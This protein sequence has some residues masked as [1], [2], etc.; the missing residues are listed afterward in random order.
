[1]FTAPLTGSSVAKAFHPFGDGWTFGTLVASPEGQTRR[2]GTYTILESDYPDLFRTYQAARNRTLRV[3]SDWSIGSQLFGN[4]RAT[5][6]YFVLWFQVPHGISAFRMTEGR[7]LELLTLMLS[8][9]LQLGEEFTF[10]TFRKY[11]SGR[12]MKYLPLVITPLQYQFF[13]YLPTAERTELAV[14]RFRLLLEDLEDIAPRFKPLLVEDIYALVRLD[15]VCLRAFSLIHRAS[16]EIADRLYSVLG[17]Y[18]A[19]F[20]YL[21]RDLP[22]S[23]AVVR[24]TYE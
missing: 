15:E 9:Y 6:N 4:D 8:G 3:P 2:S 24:Y 21:Y 5:A 1:M 7:P 22:G 16:E 23:Q 13:V 19:K 11:L 18:E 14:E 10:P 20:G 12:G 17:P